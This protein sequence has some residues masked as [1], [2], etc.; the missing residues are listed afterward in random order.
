MAPNPHHFTF[1]PVYALSKYLKPDLFH[2]YSS[3][4]L[5]VPKTRPFGN[6]ITSE[7]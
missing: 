4:L 5:Y 3:S 7:E 1:G 6:R 2:M